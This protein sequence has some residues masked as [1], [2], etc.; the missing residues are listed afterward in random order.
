MALALINHRFD[1]PYMIMKKMEHMTNKK[2][3]PLPCTSIISNIIWA[4]N[5]NPLDNEEK[6]KAQE[7][8]MNTFSNLGYTKYLYF[9]VRKH[10]GRREERHAQDNDVEMEEWAYEEIPHGSPSSLATGVHENPPPIE[11]APET[12]TRGL[13]MTGKML[14]ML[15]R[16]EGRFNM[17]D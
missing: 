17:L 9:W 1:V 10:G 8:G 3:A 5:I 11:D 12:P 2:S 6:I 14:L 4:C 15:E 7:I 16:F 13:D